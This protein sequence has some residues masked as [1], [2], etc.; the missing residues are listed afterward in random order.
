MSSSRRA[1]SKLFDFIKMQDRLENTP[2]FS[3]A[4]GLSYDSLV[5]KQDAVTI[6]QNDITLRYPVTADCL[7]PRQN[8]IS[9]STYLAVIDDVTTWA[10]VLG[11]EKRSRPGKSISLNLWA[12]PDTSVARQPGDEVDIVAS[13]QKI[14]NNIGFSNATVKDAAT[15]KHLCYA[16]HVK[17]LPMGPLFD[18][19]LSSYGWKA[20]TLYAEHFLEHPVGAQETPLTDLFDS[21]TF[22][23][24]TTA[25]FHVEPAHASLG[26]PIHGGC[27][28]VLMEMV[29]AHVA[30]RLFNNVKL[31]SI[32]IQYMSP[33]RSKSGD[34]EIRTETLSCNDATGDIISRVK[35]VGDER[36]KSEG[37]LTFSPRQL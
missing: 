23:S 29:A 28:A 17:Y 19:A 5:N 31:D 6:N 16:S 7:L 30:E 33:P 12:C 8:E 37:I 3:S 18:M 2:G 27:Q 10:L 24:D 15:N 9:L 4:L 20:T 35:L 34:I 25:T 36:T 11:D 32:Q 26:G 14:G 1:L 21:L 22:V 13:T